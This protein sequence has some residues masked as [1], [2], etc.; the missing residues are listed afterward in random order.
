MASGS[1]VLQPWSVSVNVAAQPPGT[2]PAATDKTDF[3]NLIGLRARLLLGAQEPS[4]STFVRD[5]IKTLIRS[6]NV[7]PEALGDLSKAIAA[8][9]TRRNDADAARKTLLA[10]INDQIDYF[11]K[12]HRPE[13]LEVWGEYLKALEERNPDVATFQQEID[14]VK[15][16]IDQL[17]QPQLENVAVAGAIQALAQAMTKASAGGTPT[18]ATPATGSS[19]AP[20][21]TPAPPAAPPATPA[22]TAAAPATPAPTAVMS[23]TPAP[24]AAPPATPAPTAAAPTPTAATPAT[25]TSA[26][27]AGASRPKSQTPAQ[28]PAIAKRKSRSLRHK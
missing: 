16:T 5:R 21:A 17:K 27:T 11:Q 13:A 4:A 8:E 7:T 9:K 20:P 18:S 14:A 15:V 2:S 25:G 19:A 1:I 6:A 10:E 26:P 24:T 12:G 28:K 23:A 22:P 3:R